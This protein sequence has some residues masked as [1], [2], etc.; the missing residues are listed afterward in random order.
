MRDHAYTAIANTAVAAGATIVSHTP[1]SFVVEYREF[2][3]E[4]QSEPLAN[5]VGWA[6]RISGIDDGVKKSPN[7]ALKHAIKLINAR[8]RFAADMYDGIAKVVDVV[9]AHQQK[10]AG[11]D[12]AAG[13]EVVVAQFSVEIGGTGWFQRKRAA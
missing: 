6:I 4:I 5:G 7:A 8:L 1:S 13:E 3:I 10:T 9:R 11:N 12:K 2:K